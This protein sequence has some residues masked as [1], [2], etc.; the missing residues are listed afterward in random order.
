MHHPLKVAV[1][2]NIGSGKTTVCRVFEILGIPVYYADNQAKKILF[3]KETTKR[4]VKQLGSRILDKK[5]NQID[6]QK[7]A[8]LVFSDKEKL[9]Q[10]NKIIHPLVYK[11]YESWLQKQD[12]PYCIME[13][14]IVFESGNQNFFDSTILVWAPESILIQRV[15]ERDN[16]SKKSIKER[17]NNQ[18]PQDK[19]SE[20]A[21]YIIQNDDKTMVIP[22]VI[23]I[24]KAVKNSQLK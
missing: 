20:L 23:H 16:A 21:T 18:W 6:K 14:A 17:L 1:T 4:V 5:H 7:L 11:D 12:A 10:L 2:G 22:Q 19:K 15:K 24:D 8:S 13:T 3:K 9:L